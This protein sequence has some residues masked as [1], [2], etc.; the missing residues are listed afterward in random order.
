MRRHYI[1]STC[2]ENHVGRR[3]YSLKRHYN[4]DWKTYIFC[5]SCIFTR[6]TSTFLLTWS[7]R[8]KTNKFHNDIT[9]HTWSTWQT[10]CI[11]LLLVLSRQAS[12]VLQRRLASLI[13]RQLLHILIFPLAHFIKHP[14]QQHHSRPTCRFL[15]FEG[16]HSTLQTNF[17]TWLSSKL[18]TYPV[19]MSV[20][21]CTHHSYIYLNMLRMSSFVLCL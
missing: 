21:Y 13:L 18:R 8:K 3:R 9:Q 2:S 19:F 4:W 12:P 1:I 10:I 15:A 16:L 7:W 11:L 14:I 5:K 17:H 20:F 6:T